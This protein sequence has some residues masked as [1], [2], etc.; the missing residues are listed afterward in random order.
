M[1]DFDEDLRSL[2]GHA[3]R[4]GRLDPAE[5]VRRRADRRRRGRYAATGALGL[6]LLGALTVGIAV[7]RP[8]ALPPNLPAASQSEPS[9][10]PSPSV[11]TPSSP[12]RLSSSPSSMSSDPPASPSSA[13]PDSPSRSA[14]PTTAAPEVLSGTRQVFILPK[15]NEATVAVD[16]S[17]RAGLSEDF[18]DRALFVFTPV[19]GRYLIKTAKLRVNDDPS[20][21]TFCLAVKSGK[22]VATSCD[23]SDD[24]Q[25]FHVIKSGSSSGKPTYVIRTKDYVF[26]RVADPAANL[27]ASKIEEGIADAGTD[28]LLP[29]KGKASLPALG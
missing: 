4:T 23:A 25:L 16:E 7:T 12:P 5:V 29:D 26:L 15:N 1:P 6:A 22:V 27:T 3:Q 13:Q 24:K 21:E 11:T 10:A 28:F 20:N 9:V 18:G 14:S 8:D 17:M 2:A 19:G